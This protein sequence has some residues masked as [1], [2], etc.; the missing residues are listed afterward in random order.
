MTINNPALNNSIVKQKLSPSDLQI[1]S[2][3]VEVTFSDVGLMGAYEDLCSAAANAGRDACNNLSNPIAVAAC[4]LAVNAAE[5]EC[6]SR[7]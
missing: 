5:A 3:I 4:K 7:C 1:I 2:D 6:K